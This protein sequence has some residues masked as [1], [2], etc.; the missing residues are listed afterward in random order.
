MSHKESAR[1]QEALDWLIR[2]GWIKAV[3]YKGEIFELTSTGYNKAE[4]LKEN[5][6]IN[7]ENEPLAE[8]AEF[9]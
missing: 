6:Q 4:W 5:M 3:G 8:L 1:W 9:K 2:C 7:T